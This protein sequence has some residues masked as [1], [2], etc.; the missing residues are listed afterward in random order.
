MGRFKAIAPGILKALTG[1]SFE[2]PTRSISG[3]APG[4]ET[5][6]EAPGTAKVLEVIDVPGELGFCVDLQSNGLDITT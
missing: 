2:F 5:V 4:A 6:L 3:I 1:C